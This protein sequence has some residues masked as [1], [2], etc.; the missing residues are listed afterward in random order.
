MGPFRTILFAADLSEDSKAAF[1]LACSLAGEESTRLI[2]LHVVEPDQMAAKDSNLIESR[3]RQLSELYVRK[4]RIDIEYQ[5]R[6]GEPSSEIL[7]VAQEAGADVIVMGTGRTGLCRLL[8]GSVAESVL[9]EARCPVVA[10]HSHEG[11]RLP[12]EIRVILH[13]MAISDNCDYTLRAARPLAANL[14]A[15]LVILHV[16]LRRVLMDG[17]LPPQIGLE[18]YQQFLAKVRKEAEG[19][20]LKYP[21]NIR[22]TWGNVTDEILLTAKEFAC[23]LIVMGTHERSWPRRLLMGSAAKSVLHRADL[24]GPLDQG[25]TARAVGPPRASGRREGR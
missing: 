13:P 24:S 4:D 12:E 6:K 2:V 19:S 15:R 10:L 7:R 14:G 16:S 17:S 20:D 21:A 25:P 11:R 8:A 9:R 5:S 23:D 22:L 3:K 1:A 18:Y